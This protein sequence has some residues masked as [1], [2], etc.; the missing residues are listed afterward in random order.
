MFAECNI[1][2]IDRAIRTFIGATLVIVMAPAT[3]F[4][5]DFILKYL[6]FGFG[7]LNLF[8]ATTGLCIGYKIFGV[9]TL[10]IEPSLNASPERNDF[11]HEGSSVLQSQQAVRWKIAGGALVIMLALSGSHLYQSVQ[12]SIES[13]HKILFHRLLADTRAVAEHLDDEIGE[14]KNE[15]PEANDHQI[16][17]LL[18][19]QIEPD[20]YLQQFYISQPTLLSVETGDQ[21]KWASYKLP[22]D[23]QRTII[24]FHQAY[25]ASNHLHSPDRAEAFTY[26]DDGHFEDHLLSTERG[27]FAFVTVSLSGLNGRISLIEKSPV[28]AAWILKASQQALLFLA[29]VLWVGT[30]LT[31]ILI[32]YVEGRLRTSNAQIKEAFGRVERANSELENRVRART[33]ELR[34]SEQRL[35][36]HVMNTPLGVI[37][38]DEKFQCTQWNH[39]AE[40]IFGFSSEEALGKNALYLLVP[41]VIHSQIDGV[42]HELLNQ[43]GGTRSVNENLTKDGKVVL[44][45][46]YNTPLIGENGNTIGVA[47]I[48]R[49][50][51]A[52]RETERRLKESET[53][54]RDFADTASDWFWETDADLRYVD[55]S[56]AVHNKLGIDPAEIIGRTGFELLNRG[57][58]EAMDG[59]QSNWDEHLNAMRAH[60]PVRDFEQWIVNN[61]GD[62]FH[63]SISANPVFD[64]DGEFVGYRGTGRDITELT[65]SLD[66]LRVTM[67]EISEAQKC[68]EVANQAKSAFL[69]NMSHEI[70]TPMNG[71]VGMAEILSRTDLQPEQE[72]MISTIRTSSESLLHIIDDILDLSKIEAGKLSLEAVPLCVRELTEEVMRT[73][74]PIATSS[75]VRLLFKLGSHPPF[76]KG[77][78]I[79]L[80]QVLMNLL[81]NAIK[82]SRTTDEDKKGEV[83]LRVE[84]AESGGLSFIVQDNGIGMSQE[85]ISKL[86]QPFSQAEESTTRVFGG[87]GLGLSITKT[88]V[89]LMGGE[90]EV[91]SA[92]SEGSTFT[93]IIPVSEADGNDEEPSL[94]G[95]SVLAF[96]APDFRVDVLRAYVERAGATFQSADDPELFK[97]A[98]EQAPDGTIVVLA[99]SSVVENDRVRHEISDKSGRIRYLNL[100]ENWEDGATCVLPDCFMIQRS[101]VLPSELIHGLAVLAERASPVIE[102]EDSHFVG[103]GSLNGEEELIRILLVEDNETNQDVITTQ[104]K[105]LGYGVVVANDGVE[106]L[107]ML[108]TGRFD[109]VLADCHMPNMDGLDMTREI[110]KREAETNSVKTPIVA[111]TANALK[112]E[113]ERCI[114]AGMDDFLSKPV[115]LN[116][117]KKTLSGWVAS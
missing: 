31:I 42:Y 39:A 108:S 78:A 67:S 7:L 22:E 112:G 97:S 20:T 93:V 16:R 61:K 70:R 62:R 110:R 116:E 50:I 18:L 87:T 5:D 60:K 30:W 52:E 76:I 69:A 101:P 72:R 105:M 48:V 85:V 82:F 28:D 55:V 107:E 89:D 29:A 99:R 27:E 47:S 90:I 3:P 115:K 95:I 49:D 11:S 1:N 26:L 12:T 33:E 86:F 21:H 44:C 37:A 14:L 25:A 98:H 46:W 66:T 117:L 59:F 91:Q 104:L 94:S 113:A 38:W 13:A 51:T 35:S 57:I 53:R 17:E 15:H 64:D 77:D 88:L 40:R 65:Q 63:I 34:L 71:V 73:L 106:G 68:A 6:F 109:L 10:K 23:F 4:F 96:V 43:T 24:N 83:V 54:F 100:A 80:R 103:E 58:C 75:N 8:A 111:I 102:H 41:K 81:N 19:A 92:P 74:R 79:R 56:D 2:K 9:S 32:V 36:A 45:E 84:R 114:A